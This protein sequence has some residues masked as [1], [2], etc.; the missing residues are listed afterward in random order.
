VRG[1]WN[2]GRSEAEGNESRQ[3]LSANE[4]SFGSVKRGDM[5]VSDEVQGKKYIEVKVRVKDARIEQSE[6]GLCLLRNSH[7]NFVGPTLITSL[8]NN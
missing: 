8:G 5:S 2:G 3:L 7:Q 4:E 6:R 1:Q